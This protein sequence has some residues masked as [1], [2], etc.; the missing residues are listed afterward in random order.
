MTGSLD[1][2]TLLDVAD[3]VR[4]ASPVRTAVAVLAAF[5][6]GAPGPAAPDP[7]ALDLG[8]RDARLLALRTRLFGPVFAATAACPGCAARLDVRLHADDLQFP[9]GLPPAFLEGECDGAR[10]RF[11]LPTSADL[12]AA[13]TQPGADGPKRALLRRLLIEGEPSAAVEALVADACE[14]ALPQSDVSVPLSCAGCG[15]AWE[16]LFSVDAFLSREIETR[17][18][19][20]AEDVHTLARAYGWSEDAILDLPPGRRRRYLARAAAS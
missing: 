14:A 11:R 8:T 1:G 17:A 15:E 10:I 5:D 12:I 20:L 16:A 19:R 4:G 9:S 7:A 6:P 13:G 3:A 18:E 2:R